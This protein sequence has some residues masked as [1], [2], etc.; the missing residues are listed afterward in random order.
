M[1]S[2]LPEIEFEVM[3]GQIT[4]RRTARGAWPSTSR[5]IAGGRRAGDVARGVALDQGARVTA[6]EEPET[7]H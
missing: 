7:V 2:S 5:G 6:L 3:L 1:I 4:S